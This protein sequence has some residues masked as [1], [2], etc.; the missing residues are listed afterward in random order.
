MIKNIVRSTLVIAL[1]GAV[2]GLT[3]AAR[4]ADKPK[5]QEAKG[6]IESVDTTAGTITIKHKHESKT[7]FVATDVQFSHGEKQLAMTIADL[8]VGDRV[9]VHYTDEGGKLMAH[10]VGRVEKT[11]ADEPKSK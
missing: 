3:S 10:K 8:K 1:V 4:G 9:V 5:N 7:Y 6:T 2:L 11:T